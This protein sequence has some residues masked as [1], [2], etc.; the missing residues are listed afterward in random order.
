MV[1]PPIRN[2]MGK[3][4]GFAWFQHVLEPKRFVSVL[5]NVFT[6]VCR[7]EYLCKHPSI[8]KERST[9]AGK[10]EGEVSNYDAGCTN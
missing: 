1:I 8:P 7:V 10:Q 3:R 9:S 2:K 6:V 5:V 4:F